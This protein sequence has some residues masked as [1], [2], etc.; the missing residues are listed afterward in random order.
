MSEDSLKAGFVGVLLALVVAA[1]WISRLTG[2]GW[3]VVFEAL[4]QSALVLSVVL[5]SVYAFQTSL[6]GRL[7]VSLAI[8]YPLWWSVLDSIAAQSVPAFQTFGAGSYEALPWWRAWW[9]NWG[10]EGLLIVALFRFVRKV[11]YY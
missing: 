6:T 11:N 10:T 8:I 7:A 1:I 9:F 5:L 4:W 2:A 3:I